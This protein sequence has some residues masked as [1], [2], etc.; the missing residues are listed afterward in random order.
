MVNPDQN[1]MFDVLE[2][3]RKHQL[4][5]DR[6]LKI[7]IPVVAFLLCVICANFNKWSTL[8]TFVMLWISFYAV[9]IKRSA[10]W[11]WIVAIIVYCLLDNI[12]SYGDF[13]YYPFI[14]QFGTM[15]IFLGIFGIGRP[16]FDRWLMKN[17]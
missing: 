13:K 1:E 10:L 14:R 4:Q 5:V 6:V 8:F 11:Y 17:N 3:Q 2:K 12:L 16:Y 15:F 9:A 7:V